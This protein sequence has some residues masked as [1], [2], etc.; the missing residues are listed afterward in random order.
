MPR[1][2]PFRGMYGLYFRHVLPRVGQWFAKNR[3]DAYS[4]L[5]AS[6][7]EFPDG[8]ALV[9]RMEAA[10]LMNVEFHPLTF[11]IATLYVGEKK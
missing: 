10:G 7:S 2:Q 4:Y 9:E 6:V 5:P 1:W 11:G 3:S 8:E